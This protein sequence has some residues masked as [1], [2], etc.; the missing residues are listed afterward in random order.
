LK[1]LL[2]LLRDG[3]DL[4]HLPVALDPA[5]AAVT[6]A[7]VLRAGGSMLPVLHVPV[8]LHD[9]TIAIEAD[10]GP[11]N[12]AEALVMTDARHPVESA[13]APG[14]RIEL[15]RAQPIEIAG[16]RV[17]TWRVLGASNRFAPRARRTASYLLASRHARRRMRKAGGLAMTP[18]E[19]RALDC[20]YVWPRPV[21]LVS[22]KHGDRSNLFP[23]DL[24]G[25]FGEDR[26]TLALRNTSPSVETIRESGR[27]ALSIAPAAWKE[28][29]YALGAHHRRLSIEPAELPFGLV[30]SPVFGLPLPDGTPLHREIEILDAALIGS[31]TFFMGRTVWAGDGVMPPQLAHVSGLFAAWRARTGAPFTEA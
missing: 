19:L 24:V 26:F 21:Y 9:L 16:S 31:H 6:R 3:R 5:A 29:V 1:R 23:M 22:V 13:V 28:R 27:V 20:Y 2:R 7:H 18:L 14:A 11:V 25:P 4:R 17:A 12:D 30:P 15:D 8:A 10:D